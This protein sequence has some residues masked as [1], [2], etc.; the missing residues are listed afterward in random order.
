MALFGNQSFLNYYKFRT[1]NDKSE[2][3]SGMVVIND[4]A[5]NLFIKKIKRE[6]CY[7]FLAE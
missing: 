2:S 5:I 7:K 6:N 4:S 3:V 1:G